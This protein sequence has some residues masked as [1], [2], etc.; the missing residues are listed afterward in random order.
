ME[1]GVEREVGLFGKLGIG[2]VTRLGEAIT[3]VTDK[4]KGKGKA[5]ESAPDGG[6][7]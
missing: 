1:G 3:M 2:S 6:E 5:V 7:E 4:G